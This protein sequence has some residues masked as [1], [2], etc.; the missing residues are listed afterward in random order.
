[1]SRHGFDEKWLTAAAAAAVVSVF[2]WRCRYR[3]RWWHNVRIVNTP[4]RSNKTNTT[5]IR[6]CVYRSSAVNRN[7][8]CGAMTMATTTTANRHWY[9][10]WNLNKTKRRT[11]W[12]YDGL[13]IN[14][15]R[16]LGDTHVNTWIRPWQITNLNR[17]ANFC[18]T[19]KYSCFA[20]SWWRWWRWSPSCHFS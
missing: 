2:L 14:K 1:M 20:F 19:Q 4:D 3:Q 13:F 7:G 15:T 18:L 17:R 5:R 16:R 9:V 6:M 8:K 11:K 10:N 12:Y